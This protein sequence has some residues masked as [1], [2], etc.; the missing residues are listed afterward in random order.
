MVLPVR[1]HPGADDDLP[2]LPGP[3]HHATR[4]LSRHPRH[5]D[6]HRDPARDGVRDRRVPR[7]RH[8]RLGHERILLP[9]DLDLGSGMVGRVAVLLRLHGAGVHDRL[10]LGNALQALRAPVGGARLHGAGTAARRRDVGHRA[11][12][13]LGAGVHLVRGSG[14]GRNHPVGTAADRGA[15]SGIVPDPSSRDTQR[16]SATIRP[17][18]PVPVS[19]GGRR[20][21]SRLPRSVARPSAP[22]RANRRTRPRTG[23]APA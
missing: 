12:R 20:R 11:P 3:Q 21:R 15:R 8:R 7:R 22:A 14:G 16:P 6:D 13:R 4:V 23:P 2:V 18:A 5:R 10:R 1:R 19:A 17:S 9:A